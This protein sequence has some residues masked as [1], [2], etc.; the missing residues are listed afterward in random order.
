MSVW[1]L[2]DGV[3]DFTFGIFRLTKLILHLVEIE[4]NLILIFFVLCCK[5][6]NSGIE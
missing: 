5:F 3:Y 2:N 4:W 6:V 1:L